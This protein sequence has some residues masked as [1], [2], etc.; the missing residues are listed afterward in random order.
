[1]SPSVVKL[2]MV[3][4]DLYVAGFRSKLDQSYPVVQSISDWFGS[5]A[6]LIENKDSNRANRFYML[7]IIP[8]TLRVEEGYILC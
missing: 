4:Y 8:C 1:M 6:L 3:L 7:F 5:T 2:E